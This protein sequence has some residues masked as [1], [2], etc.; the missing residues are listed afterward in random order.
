MMRSYRQ[1]WRAR[2]WSGHLV[3]AMTRSD[4]GTELI[5]AP[6]GHKRGSRQVGCGFDVGDPYNGVGGRSLN[7]GRRCKIRHDR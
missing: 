3:H 4:A 7:G 6:V 5:Q 2:R 1:M